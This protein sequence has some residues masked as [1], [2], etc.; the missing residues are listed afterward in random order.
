MATSME[1]RVTMYFPAAFP[2]LAR[3]ITE[4]Q[5]QCLEKEDKSQFSEVSI[6]SGTDFD[7]GRD[8]DR[9]RLKNSDVNR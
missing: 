8:S 7:D 2:P 6:C 5:Y 3:K 1:M 4:L 9:P